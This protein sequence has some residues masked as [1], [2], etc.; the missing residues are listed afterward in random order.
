VV[1]FLNN[2]AKYADENSVTVVTISVDGQEVRVDVA[3]K[4]PTSKYPS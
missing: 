4:S 2:A 3:D 1:N